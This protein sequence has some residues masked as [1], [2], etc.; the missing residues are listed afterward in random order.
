MVR[1]RVGGCAAEIVKIRKHDLWNGFLEP[2]IRNPLRRESLG[3]QE[4]SAGELPK[5]NHD[6]RKPNGTGRR[7]PGGLLD[8]VGRGPAERR[9]GPGPDRPRRYRRGRHQCEGTRSRRV[10]DCRNDR[11]ADQVCAHCRDRRPG[12]VRPARSAQG[13]LS[14][15]RPRLRPGR[16]AAAVGKARTATQPDG[17]GG[18]RRDIGGAGLSRRLV[19]FHAAR[20][21]RRPRAGAVPANDEGVLRLPPARGQGDARVPVVRHRRDPSGQVGHANEVWAIWSVDGRLF[22]AV[23]RAAESIRGLDRSDRQRRSADQ[24][25]A[26]SHRRPAQPRDLT[27]GLGIAD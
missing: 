18:A 16:F 13:R 4:E 26:P 15:V 5:R 14:G 19:V 10:G 22:P 2:I 3:S 27:L 24:C 1:N 6:N 20:A 7:H 17:S 12:A 11:S 23:R 8:D 21:R 9:F 25:A